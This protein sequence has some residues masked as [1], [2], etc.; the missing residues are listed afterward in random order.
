MDLRI[1]AHFLSRQRGDC[2]IR[3]GRLLLLCERRQP[4]GFYVVALS[5]ELKCTAARVV[6][7]HCSTSFST[8][9]GFS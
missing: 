6:Y 2:T 8:L 9:G 3:H 5:K 7:L 4:L 1:I